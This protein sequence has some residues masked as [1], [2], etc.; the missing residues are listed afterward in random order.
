MEITCGNWVAKVSDERATAGL[1]E[2]EATYLMHLACGMT[3][4][5]IARAT[6]RQ[7]STVKHGLERAF[8][9]LGVNRATAAVAKAQAIGWIRP[10]TKTLLCAVL[11]IAL[12]MGTEDGFRRGGRTYRHHRRDVEQ[13]ISI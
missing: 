2:M 8:H 12:G 7:P 1:T 4:K 6:G 11:A 13:H 10:V 9:R 3:R 5:E